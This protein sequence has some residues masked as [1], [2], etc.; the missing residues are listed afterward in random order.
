M[1]LEQQ[2]FQDLI[3]TLKALSWLSVYEE[4]NQGGG[5]KW[6]LEVFRGT[7]AIDH[8]IGCRKISNGY[9]LTLNTNG[10]TAPA[11]LSERI[12]AI[13]A[14]ITNDRRRGGN[15]QSTIMTPDGW[16]PDEDEGREAFS[17]STSLIILL[18]EVS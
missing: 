3:T 2:S 13:D 8:A 6:S 5:R 4:K 16:T 1:G 17:I 14:A 11:D 12:N 7:T 15:A 18:H 9:S 10:T